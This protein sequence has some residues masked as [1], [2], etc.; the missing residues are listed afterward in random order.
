LTAVAIGVVIIRAALA[1]DPPGTPD[2][3]TASAQS[4]AKAARQIDQRLADELGVDVAA[5]SS[6]R[7]D[8]ETFARR[9]YLDI[10]GQLPEAEAVTDLVQSG[11]PEKRAALVARLLDDPRY[12]ENWAKYWR[13]VIMYRRIDERSRIATA[14]LEEYFTDALERNRPW[15]EVARQMITAEG[16]ITE[17]GAT[18]LIAAQFGMHEEVAAEVSRVFLGIQ[19]QCAQCHDHVT[20]RW[21]RVQFHELAAFFPRVTLRPNRDR[22]GRTFE[23]MGV[24]EF[25]PRQRANDSSIYTADAEHYMAN[26]ENPKARGTLIRPKFF[27]NGKSLP[28][29]SSDELRRATL[30]R[31]ITE[32]ANPWFAR[33][34]VNRMWSELV[35]TGFYEPVDDMG[36]DRQATAPQTL[37]YLCGQFV[38]HGYDLKWLIATIVSTDAYQQSAAARGGEDRDVAMVLASRA[39]PLRGDQLLNALQHAL[40]AP[41][42]DQM[43]RLG[44]QGG[45]Q[46]LERSVRNGFNTLFGYDPSVPRDEVTGSIPRALALM[47]SPAIDRLLNAPTGSVRMIVESTPSDEEA[48]ELVYLQV[49]ARKPTTQESQSCLA[50][51]EAAANRWEAYQDIAW[52]LINS[53]E[54][55]HRL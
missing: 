25:R 46:S 43:T 36:P 16:D 42:E 30:A 54:F 5:R 51:V 22:D 35:G 20:D 31:W 21:T 34:I 4:P 28:L 15:N 40:G 18:G 49:L 1:D 3:T 27:V 23:A 26:L 9:V 11:D 2:R 12:A 29:G 7:V 37:D 38:A 39:Q 14:A 44:R 41:T 13:D 47:N 33:A 48:I 45:R 19:I 53:A 10:I 50:Y 6:S 32:P 17:N 55:A 8:D 52:A 24:D